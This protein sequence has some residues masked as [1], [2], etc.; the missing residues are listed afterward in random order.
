MG[1]SRR[2]V[3]ARGFLTVVGLLDELQPPTEKVVEIALHH[4]DLV[5]YFEGFLAH[6]PIPANQLSDQEPIEVLNTSLIVG[7]TRASSCPVDL[8]HLTPL[9]SGVVQK[10]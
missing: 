2:F 4:V 1:S 3:A 9:D 6:V 7:P 8:S 10:F 5:Q